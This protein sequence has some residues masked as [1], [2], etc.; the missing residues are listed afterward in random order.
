MIATQNTFSWKQEP[1]LMD[2]LSSAQ[3]SP[4]NQNIDIMT[5]AGMCDSREE[6]LRHVER[7][8]ARAAA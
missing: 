6:L 2:R 3:N 7:Y 8:E 1:E 5:F 4:K